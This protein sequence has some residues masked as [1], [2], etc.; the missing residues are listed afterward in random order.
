MST[1][2]I[3]IN[4]LILGGIV[5]FS[6][7]PARFNLHSEYILAPNAIVKPIFDYFLKKFNCG[8]T[9]SLSS[10]YCPCDENLPDLY[11]KVGETQLIIS[12]SDYQVGEE[13]EIKISYSNSDNWELGQP[14]F[15]SYS[16][17]LSKTEGK[18]EIFKSNEFDIEEMGQGEEDDGLFSLGNLIVI[19]E[20]VIGCFV[21]F[22]IARMAY[23]YCMT[24]EFSPPEES[25]PFLTPRMNTPRGCISPRR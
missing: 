15:R 16:V 13:C 19:G 18:I 8:L 4:G 14:F 6:T 9:V 12:K 20:I 7:S 5:D 11:I 1:W 2:E 23:G 17:M 3:S 22:I 10:I 25:Q 21:I 24:V